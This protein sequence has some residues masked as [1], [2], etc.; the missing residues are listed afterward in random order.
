MEEDLKAFNAEKGKLIKDQDDQAD[1]G[2][3]KDEQDV[4]RSLFVTQEDMALD[5]F[6]KEKDEEV[7]KSLEKKLPAAKIQQGWGS[8]AG[9]GID[10][11]KHEQRQAK[12]DQL[13]QKKID[14]LKEKRQD[15]KMKGVQINASEQRD[16]KFA[17]KFLV[18]ELPK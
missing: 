5:D 3:T 15:A 8:W 10:T 14:M 18:K 13:R 2:R 12:L 16:K 4:L 17:N 11:Q 1:N 9:D 6:E 7:T